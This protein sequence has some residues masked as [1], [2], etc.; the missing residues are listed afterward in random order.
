MSLK[1]DLE[2]YRAAAKI[3]L[4]EMTARH[5]R[6]LVSLKRKLDREA[7]SPIVRLGRQLTTARK[8]LERFQDHYFARP[9]PRVFL[10]TGL[11]L[12][13]L[14]NMRVHVLARALV[15][16]DDLPK[17]CMTQKSSTVTPGEIA[18]VFGG[19]CPTEEQLARALLND[20]SSLIRA[21]GARGIQFTAL[22][23]MFDA[24]T[25]HVAAQMPPLY[26]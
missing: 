25:F 15:Q 5:Q 23:S 3:A 8:Q 9:D 1:D 4:P 22:A 20:G 12:H 26:T 11:L 18:E 21:S 19:S 7:G 16:G 13:E 17:F 2:T 14:L 10:A 24:D 6:E